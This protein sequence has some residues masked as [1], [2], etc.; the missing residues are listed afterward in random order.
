MLRTMDCGRPSSS[1]YSCTLAPASMAQARLWKREQK[2]SKSQRTRKYAVRLLLLEMVTQQDLKNDSIIRHP[3]VEERKSHRV[4]SLDYRQPMT[5][6]RERISLTQWRVPWSI[7]HY[8]VA[9]PETIYTQPT[10]MDSAVSIYFLSYLFNFYLIYVHVH[11]KNNK[12][13]RGYWFGSG[14]VHGRSSRKGI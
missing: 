8:K 13:K 4:P 1:S 9:I 12:R 7:V 10:N 11:S 5:A 3:N 2:E 14:G 6:K